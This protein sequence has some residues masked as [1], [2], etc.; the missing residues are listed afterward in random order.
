M[1]D[2]SAELSPALVKAVRIASVPH[3]LRALVRRLDRFQLDVAVDDEAAAYPAVAQLLKLAQL[4]PEHVDLHLEKGAG[5]TGV[6]VGFDNQSHALDLDDLSRGVE[7]ALQKGLALAVTREALLR[8]ASRA[9]QEL[10]RN[11]ELRANIDSMITA[12]GLE[13]A[14]NTFLCGVTWGAGLGFH[15]A[16]LFTFVPARGVFCGTLGV[17][18]VGQAGTARVAEA[19]LSRQIAN[20]TGSAAFS[21]RVRRIELAAADGSDEVA[22]ALGGAGPLFIAPSGVRSKGLAKLDPAKEFVLA[23]IM[24]KGNILGLL[25]ADMRY[26]SSGIDRGRVRALEAYVAQA[27][28][29][30]QT[31]KLVRDVEELGRCD[32]LTGLWNRRELEARLANERSRAMRASQ[33]LS[34][35]L[36]DLDNFRDTNHSRGH[37]AGDA[38]LRRLGKMLREELRAHDTGARFG[39]DELAVVLPGAGA[40]EAAS[41]ARRVGVMALRRGLSISIGAASFPDDTDHPDDLITLADKNLIAAKAAGRGRA[42]LSEGGEPIVFAQED[43]EFAPT[44]PSSLSDADG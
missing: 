29:A 33:P 17:G 22:A 44:P 31:L 5:F 18:P 14:L 37:D 10:A 7:V 40:L 15:R 28:L 9:T 21:D 8:G 43:A 1:A 4:E 26:D 36:I 12:D 19:P 25:F 6:L 35:L 3:S 13:Q 16:A 39:D 2:L 11:E 32:A 27:G 42:C 34:V 23:R 38:L 20:A 30:W 24:G 41:V